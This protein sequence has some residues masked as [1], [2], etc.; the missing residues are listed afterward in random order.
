MQRCPAGLVHIR[1]LVDE[2][3]GDVELAPD[4]GH[5]QGAFV[6]AVAGFDLDVLGVQQHTQRVGCRFAHSQQ[7]AGLT[8]G[9]AGVGVKTT[10]QQ[11]RQGT[12][13]V[14]LDGREEVL[15]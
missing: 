8:F 9:V 15:E 12:R 13:I 14:A 1:I 6:L 10:L 7:Q 3:A 11:S 4:R 5:H 2:L